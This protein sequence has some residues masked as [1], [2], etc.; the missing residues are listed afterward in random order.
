MLLWE[1]EGEADW[2]GKGIK[3]YFYCHSS[4]YSFNIFYF[5]F[6]PLL[7]PVTAIVSINQVVICFL[8][9]E[10]IVDIPKEKKF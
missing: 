2:V 10:W 4:S 9:L 1:W 3:Y 8:L 7:V 6:V 5:L